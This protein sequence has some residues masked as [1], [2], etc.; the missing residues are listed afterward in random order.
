MRFPKP[1]GTG[2]VIT[3]EWIASLVE[4]LRVII[5]P[6][7]PLKFEKGRNSLVLTSEDVGGGELLT[8]KSPPG[9]IAAGASALCYRFKYGEPATLLSSQVLVHNPGPDAVPASRRLWYGTSD[10]VPNSALFWS[11]NTVA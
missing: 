10:G 5:R 2:E 11:C 4:V 8:C 3:E 9:G 1:L 7:L 6:K